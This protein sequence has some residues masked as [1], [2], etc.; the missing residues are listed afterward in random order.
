[1]SLTTGY[2]CQQLR[3]SS[4]ATQQSSG[5]K[6]TTLGAPPGYQAHKVEEQPRVTTEWQSS[7]SA[8]PAQ[9]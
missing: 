5:A 9:V 2:S 3:Q 7:I 8:N 6:A 1:M 4:V